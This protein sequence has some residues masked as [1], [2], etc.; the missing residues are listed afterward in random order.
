MADVGIGV[1]LGLLFGPSI[2]GVSAAGVA[3]PVAAAELGIDAPASAWLLTVHALALGVG[4]ALF[5]RLGDTWGVRRSLLAGSALLVTGAVACL[6]APDLGTAVAGRFV[7]AAGSGA[8]TSS[9]VTLSVSTDPARRAAVLSWFGAVL[10]IFA[11]SAT[12]VGGLVASAL[13]W[14]VVLVL[15]VLSLVAVGS[16]MSLAPQQGRG[17]GVDGVGAGL[18]TTAVAAL[19]VL[20]QAPALRL[21]VVATVLLGAV[22]IAAG[23]LL[24]A[25]TRRRPDGFVPQRLVGSRSFLAAAAV[26]AG[27][28]GGLFAAM[29]AA[30][31]LLVHGHGW[32]VLAVGL[33]LLPGAL[34][35][36]VTSRSA[37]R[38]APARGR[39]LLGGAAGLTGVLLGA[40][41]LAGG[42]AWLVLAG[43]STA[44]VGFALT[45]AVV[46]A[47]VG[48]AVEPEG[49]GTALGLLNL[50]FLVG[51]A[52]GSA[53][54]G[55]LAGP[56]GVSGALV[57]AAVLPLGATG[58]I[59]WIGAPAPVPA[60][61]E[62]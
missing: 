21:P 5:G 13:S 17:G 33:V 43:T 42:P 7:L 2:F 40:A 30:P 22:V 28:F 16:A 35:G 19:L 58:A 45:Q 38:L 59:H 31:Q 25:R 9:A 12:A 10:A 55:G 32:S 4:T 34:L 49:R 26:G 15:P 61:T 53:V 3:L 57:V 44:F 36:A 50:M 47:A 46:T 60:R 23:G 29:F 27:V 11:G 62:K 51:G 1:R 39:Q 48:A 6:L 37:G 20:L 41:G 24:V 54:A 18:L 52:V 56:L 8:M 14:R